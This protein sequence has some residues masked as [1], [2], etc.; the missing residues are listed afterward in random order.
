V[1]QLEALLVDA[2][3]WLMRE[4][5]E[6]PKSRHFNFGACMAVAIAMS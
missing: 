5:S 1:S 4:P 2:A 3:R 6:A